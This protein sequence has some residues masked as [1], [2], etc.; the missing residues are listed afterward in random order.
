MNFVAD[1]G[2][3]LPIVVRLRELGYS[4]WYVAEI[5]PSVDDAEVL[6]QAVEQQAVL[7]TFDKDFGEMVFRQHHNFPG[8][9]LL[10][11]HGL[12]MGQKTAVVED[13]LNQHGTE[14]INSFTVVTPIKIRIR[15]QK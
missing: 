4:V 8:I 14:L 9:V 12:T 3:D 1:E 10:R 6:V 13:L 2:I 11:L 5:S 15:P 7:L